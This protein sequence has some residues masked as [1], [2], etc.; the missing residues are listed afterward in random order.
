[1]PVFESRPTRLDGKVVRV[2]TYRC[3][4][5]DWSALSCEAITQEYPD[6]LHLKDK[7][8]KPCP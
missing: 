3:E 8:P 5:C 4:V 7:L 6:T 1:V 2:R